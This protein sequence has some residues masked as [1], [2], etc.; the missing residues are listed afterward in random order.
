[1]FNSKLPTPARLEQWARLRIVGKR[2]YVLHHGLLKIGTYM[3]FILGGWFFLM[4][5]GLVVLLVGGTHLPVPL[6][7]RARFWPVLL[8]IAMLSYTFGY[9]VGRSRWNA[10]EE[11][12]ESFAQQPPR[13]NHNAE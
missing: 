5:T 2:H 1:M 8:V 11:W 10:N 4:E 12:Y 9:I 13:V 7:I 3:F 6:P